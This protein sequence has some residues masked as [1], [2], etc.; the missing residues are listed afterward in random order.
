[1]QTIGEFLKNSRIKNQY[2]LSDIEKGTKIKKDFVENIEEESWEKLPEYPVVTGF[3]KNIASYLDEDPKKCVALLRRDYPP[4]SLRVSPKPDISDKFVWSP[5]LTFFIGAALVV[6]A[7]ISYLGFQYIDFISPPM[8]TI[9]KP[10]DQEV[11]TT[12]IIEVVGKTDPDATV[13]VNSQSVIIDQDGNFIEELEVS[14]KT[15]KIEVKAVS[16]S[17]KE[18]LVERSVVVML[19]E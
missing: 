11:L 18:T 3:V 2:S 1:M 13:I 8:L 12:R 9:I 5:K 16:R 15:D 6:A 19:D 10:E 7:I 4:K 14:G 17:G